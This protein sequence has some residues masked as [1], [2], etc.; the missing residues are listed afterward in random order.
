[1]NI[2]RTAA[3]LS[4]GALTFVGG[5][6]AGPPDDSEAQNGCQGTNEAQGEQGGNGNTGGTPAEDV[7][8][9]V[10]DLLTGEDE[11]CDDHENASGD[12]GRPGDDS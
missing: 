3:A 5:F 7:L 10:E 8:H 2:R 12:N 6:A 1:M 11:D 4:I 9:D